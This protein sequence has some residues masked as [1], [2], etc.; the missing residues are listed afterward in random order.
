MR[1]CALVSWYEERP[2]WLREMVASLSL[3][4]VDHLVCV[5]GGYERFP[6]ARPRSDDAQHKALIRECRKRNIGL[7]LHIPNRIWQTEMEKRSYLFKAGELVT[8]ETDWYVVMDADQTID[9]YPDDLKARLAGTDFDSAR[10][11]FHEPHPSKK[12]RDFSLPILF[13]AIR[14]LKVQG[15]HYNYL[16]PDNRVLWGQGRYETPLN[17]ADEL[18]VFHR[19]HFRHKA[20]KERSIAYYRKRDADKV[21]IGNCCRCG[22]KGDHEIPYEWQQEPTDAS[23]PSAG[24][25]SAIWVAVCDE[26]LPILK[27]ENDERIRSFG[28]VPARIRPT[29]EL[30]DELDLAPR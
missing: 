5:D 30:V 22:E 11:K 16:T 27:E 8:T 26:C 21:E 14:G 29:F 10:A 9:R 20:R 2:D 12:A 28:M 3:L 15:N 18:R 7:S 4:N 24:K 17:L 25:L 23:H 1:L 6:N 13:R 19:T